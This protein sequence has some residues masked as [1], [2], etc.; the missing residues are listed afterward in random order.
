MQIDVSHIQIKSQ[1]VEFEKL[2]FPTTP[3]SLAHIITKLSATDP[4]F[5]ELYCQRIIEVG[6][7]NQ[8]EL[9]YKYG[10]FYNYITGNSIDQAVSQLYTQKQ[11]LKTNLTKALQHYKYYFP[12]AQIPKIYTYISGFSQSI[13]VAD[14]LIGISLDK[15]LGTQNDIYERL[16]IEKFRIRKMY[17]ER[18]PS[19]VMLAIAISEFPEQT[20]QT[21]LLSSMI[22]KGK[23]LYF[24]DATLPDTPDSIKIG[25]TSHEMRWAEH[26]EKDSWDYLVEKKIVFDTN[27]LEI[28]KFTGEAPY[29]A[30]FGQNSPPEIGSW[31]GWQIV[32]SYMRSNPEVSLR[33]LMHN[34]DAAAI[35]RHSKY[36]P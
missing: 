3:D 7:T 19:D 22:Y 21:D 14:S 16:N 4:I 13:V 11:T 10:Q 28:Q 26:N 12:Q 33:E 35:L 2:S 25:Y 30:P 18:I 1:F 24:L 9:P 34:N 29:T 5:F 15:Y 36:R 27:R 32:R 20:N 23:T 31:L 6:P 8:R 17:P